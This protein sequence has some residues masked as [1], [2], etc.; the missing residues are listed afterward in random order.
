MRNKYHGSSP[1][2]VRGSLVLDLLACT[3][4]RHYQYLLFTIFSPR[5]CIIF[6]LTE[7]NRHI[8]FC[9]QIQW[10]EITSGTFNNKKCDEGS[11]SVRL[12]NLPKS[13]AAILQSFQKRNWGCKGRLNRK[14]KCNFELNNA[15]TTTFSLCPR[16]IRDDLDWWILHSLKFLDYKYQN[17]KCGSSEKKTWAKHF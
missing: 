12:Q 9:Q 10:R 8:N 15:V 7:C 4:T 16:K 17:N 11:F 2:K 1:R 14:R 13:K 3:R 5:I 6:V